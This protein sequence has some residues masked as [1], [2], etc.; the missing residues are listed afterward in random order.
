[1]SQPLISIIIPVKNSVQ[2]IKKCLKSIFDQTFSSFEVLILDAVSTDG[3]LEEINSFNKKDDRLRIYSEKD[4]GTYDAMNKGIRLAKGKWLFFLGSDDQLYDQQVLEKISKVLSH[5]NAKVVYGNV[6]IVGDTAWAKDG[7]IYAGRFTTS[8]LLNQN[9][10]HQAIFYQSDLL[11]KELTPYNLDYFKSADWDLNLHCW[12]KGEFTYTDCIIA[13]YATGGISADSYDHQ[14]SAD[15]VKNV[16]KY[17]G[18]TLFD[19]LINN[20]D[21]VYYKDVLKLQK[22]KYPLRYLIAK[23]N[24]VFLR[25]IHKFVPSSVR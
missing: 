10:C 24:S 16:M 2:T 14:L 5:S 12:S 22:E 8:K 23:L 18:F 13:R 21:F 15:F 17:F 19:P 1:M 4:R 3:T 20:P 9:I 7:E 11:T 25:I 6:L